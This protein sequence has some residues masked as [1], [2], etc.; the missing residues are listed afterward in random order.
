MEVQ[1]SAIEPELSIQEM[2]VEED[3]TE[4]QQAAVNDCDEFLSDYPHSR[5]APNV[6][7][8]KGRALDMRVDRAYFRK[9]AIL[10][11]YLDFPSEAS[12]STWE[13]LLKRQDSPL[14]LVAAHRVALL[15]G[16][17]GEIDK[18]VAV[19][20]S[21]LGWR[22]RTQTQPDGGP[23]VG[24]AASFFSKRPAS[25]ALDVDPAAVLLAAQKL[26]LLISNNR[27]PQQNDL[28][29]VTLLRFDPRHP[30]YRVNLQ[31]MLDDIPS[32]YPL[33]PLCDNLKTMI[34][35]D[36][37]N[38][39][40][41]RIELLRA[42]VEWDSHAP[43]GDALPMAKLELGVAYKDAGRLEE[44]RATLESLCKDHSE[45][46]WAVD[47]RQQLAAMGVGRNGT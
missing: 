27:D 47:A 35:A 23:G 45:S 13:Q 6:L 22:A 46:P 37:S 34:A 43:V 21:L 5:Y 30:M 15:D 10:R 38:P 1:W 41:R 12:L 33:T 36:R 8:L 20:E 19:L 44:A 18:A 17:R 16:R 39:P 9:T 4:E 40:G 3:F 31:Q 25:R 29:L 14:W 24:S 26:Y 7:Y 28:P 2:R 11:H 32:K 42:C